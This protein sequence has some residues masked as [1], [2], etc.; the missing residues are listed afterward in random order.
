VALCAGENESLRNYKR[1]DFDRQSVQNTTVGQN[2]LVAFLCAQ[3]PN[4]TCSQFNRGQP[5]VAAVILTKDAGQA[6]N[7]LR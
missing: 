2:S 5:T 4:K 6:A 7:V 3:L 1:C